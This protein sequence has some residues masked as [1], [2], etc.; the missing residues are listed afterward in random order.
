MAADPTDRE[1]VSEAGDDAP[2]AASQHRRAAELPN[3]TDPAKCAD[4]AH[5]EASH[6]AAGAGAEAG[7]QLTSAVVVIALVSA[8]SG[9]LYG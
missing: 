3:G 7:N 5:E 6:G 9:L 8:I 4:A 2:T 1:W